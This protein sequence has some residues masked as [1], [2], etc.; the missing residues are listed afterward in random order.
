MI[1]LVAAADGAYADDYSGAY[2]G[3][4]FGRARN[5]YGTGFIDDQIES[6][7]AEESAGVDIT[8]RSTRRLSDVWWANAG[9]FFNPYVGLDAAFI[10]LGDFK[11]IAAGT[12]ATSS[13]SQS[14]TTFNEISS[15]GPA[16][17]LILRLPLAE[18]FAADLR[19]GD[20]YGKATFADTLGV[21]SNSALTLRSA[22]GSSLLAGVG[23]SYTVDGHFSIRLDYI[24]VDKTGDD[25][26]VGKF[27]VN[28]A[29]AG[30][31]YTF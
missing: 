14:L 9:Y 16:I 10:H 27:S 6:G 20:Y 13:E 5:A 26:S 8:E 23:A 28:A 18:S 25:N 29:T 22:N 15:H 24:R 30:V 19:I 11:Y 31:S 1:F 7:A 21:G 2:I 17:S 12:I 4:N 3:G